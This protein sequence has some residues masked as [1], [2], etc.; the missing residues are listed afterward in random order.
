MPTMR[1][2]RSR[3]GDALLVGLFLAFAWANF[4]HWQQTGRPSGIGTTLLE[5]W[6]AVMFLARR[7]PAQVS[8]SR[9]AWI[10]AP[11]GSFAMLLARPEPAGLAQL[12]CEALQL[13]GVG[14]ALISLGMLGR[15]FGF[16]AANR[17]IK[18]VGAYG[19]V[20][21]PAYTSY[22]VAYLGY[23]AENPSLRNAMLLGLSTLFQ[24][25]RIREE[26]RILRADEG[27]RAYARHVRFRLVPY[28][29]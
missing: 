11:I 4:H 6:V 20:R 15:S 5:A 27:Y 10:A 21:H 29:Y 22:A 24:L 17:G 3:L 16:V 26:E 23:V 25:V 18:T 14:V 28:V 1:R 9:L 13:L 2:L 19:V 8:R 12:P 7:H